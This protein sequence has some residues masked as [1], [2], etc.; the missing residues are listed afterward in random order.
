MVEPFEKRLVVDYLKQEHKM[1]ISRACS[2]L[3]ISRTVY[4]Y[5]STKD[6][7]EVIQKLNELADQHS[8]RG[9]DN[10]Y[11]RLRAQGYKWNRKRVLRIYRKMKLGLRSKRKRRFPSRALLSLA[12]PLF[13]N[14]VWSMDFMS[15]SLENGRRVRVL[16]I[17]DDYNREAILI[18]PQFYYPGEK[19]VAALEILMSERGL[20]RFIRVDNG[21]E[22]VCQAV[23]IFLADKPTEMKLIEPG[24]PMQNAFIERFN[25]LFRED[26]L[27]AHIF[28]DIGQL[29]V[30]SHHWQEDYNYNHPHQ[31]LGGIS[32]IQFKLL[33]SKENIS[34]ELVK[35]KV[36]D[37][38]I[39]EATLSSALTKSPEN[40]GRASKGLN[41]NL[42]T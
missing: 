10:Y 27:D 22:F 11:L 14:E 23:E 3:R 8:T 13:S 12:Q 28:S 39:R 36:I 19:V 30:L 17:M 1:S 41:E 6:D 4:R 24:K 18:D 38:R 29:R 9:F 34:S 33:L 42:L 26:I 7:T 40:I 20:P 15:D 35:A 21:P 31:S 16:N 2:L 32:P 5:H 37:E 25:R